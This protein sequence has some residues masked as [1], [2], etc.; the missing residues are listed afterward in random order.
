MQNRPTS[1]PD[2]ARKWVRRQTARM[3]LARRVRARWLA[4]AEY[5]AAVRN[6]HRPPRRRDGSVDWAAIDDYVLLSNSAYFDMPWTLKDLMAGPMARFIELGEDTSVNIRVRARQ[7]EFARGV[8]A[9]FRRR[10]ARS[11]EKKR[12]VD[13]TIMAELERRFGPQGSDG[14]YLIDVY[15]G[16]SDHNG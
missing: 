5:E 2:R 6:R 13:A 4:R 11:E 3:R 16:K 7:M 14:R 9:G 15:L 10:R 12:L 1:L 8:A